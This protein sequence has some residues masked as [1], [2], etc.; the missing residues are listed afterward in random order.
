MS[1]AGYN[2]PRE[3]IQGTEYMKTLFFDCFSGISGDMILGALVD[4]G[5]DV[6]ALRSELA[7]LDIKGYEI[8]SGRTLRNGIS[9]ARITVETVET[10]KE[11]YYPEITDIINRSRLSDHVRE[12]SL[13]IFKDLAVAEGKIHGMDHTKAHFHEIGAVDSIIDIT[14][15]AVCL[16]KLKVDSVYS[17]KVHVGT[18]F[19]RCGHGILPVPVPAV[20]G[21]LKGIPVYSSGIESELVTP[22]GAA[23]LKNIASGFGDMPEMTIT[24]TGYGAGSKELDIPNALRVIAGESSPRGCYS[25]NVALIETNIDDMN[26]E[27]FSHISDLLFA[28]KKCLDV[29]M[30]PVYMKKNRP[31]TLLSVVAEPRMID[32]ILKVLFSETT[33]LGVRIQEAR[34]KKLSREIISVKTG[35]GEIDIKISREGDRVINISPE[36]ESCRRIALKTGMPLKDVYDRAKNLGISALGPD[37]PPRGAV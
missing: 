1:G 26:P 20:T 28:G 3:K 10:G 33:T 11:R 16:E 22:T 36:Y 32:E 25:D 34:R 4:L 23:I 8:K 14:G 9:C 19:V 6:E 18:G 5:V 31:G 35:S 29:Y 7:G 2:Y 27:I 15:A 12:L 30:T 24:G 37:S 21:L 17:S 13:R